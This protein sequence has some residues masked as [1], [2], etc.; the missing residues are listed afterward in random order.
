MTAPLS[1]ANDTALHRGAMADAPTYDDI[2]DAAA[3]LRGVAVRTPLLEAALLNERAGARVFVKAE[4]L[5][6]TGSFKLRGAWNRIGRLAD[7][8]KKNGVLCFSSGNHA[9]AVASSARLA[10]TTATVL[11]PATAPALKVARCRA[12]GATVI[13]HDGDR[14]SMVAR[15]ND[16]AEAEGRILVPPFDDPLVIAGQGT[17]GL[18][19]AE[20]L[21]AADIVPDAVLVPCGG[22][23]LMAGTAIAIKERFPDADLYGVEPVGFDDTVRSLAAGSPVANEPGARTICDALMVPEPGAI[24]FAVNRALLTGALAVDD[25]AVRGAMAA[26]F[27]HLKIVTEPGGAVALAAL[28]SGAIDLRGKTV[29]VVASGGNVDPSIFAAAIIPRP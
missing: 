7:S 15:A 16:I 13:L 5:Q 3:C 28:L 9:Q 1:R 6:K 12:F 4:M 8:Q 2:V 11:M 29:A 14:Y 21:A 20:D 18:E 19:I 26:A 17:V 23:G 24:T 27:E 10:G 22:G 25:D